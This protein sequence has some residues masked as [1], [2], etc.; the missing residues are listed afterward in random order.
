MTATVMGLNWKHFKILSVGAWVCITL[1]SSS[2]GLL[3]SSRLRAEYPAVNPL[4]RAFIVSDVSKANVSFDIE[5]TRGLPLYHLQCH[6]AGYTG[7]PDFDYSGDF[8]CR[9]SLIGQP[10]SYSTLLTEDAHQSKDWESRGRFFAAELQGP[11]ARIPEFGATRSFKLRNMDLTLKITDQKF[12]VGGKLRSLTLTVTV[13]PDPR[14]QRPIAEIV[15]LP[16]TGIPAECGLRKYFV[17]YSSM[18]GNH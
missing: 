17:D 15:P 13:V 11:C 9:L 12:T 18:P 10:N 2:F 6:S 5:T 16:K 14:A 4:Q 8:E 1:M 7:D 3:G